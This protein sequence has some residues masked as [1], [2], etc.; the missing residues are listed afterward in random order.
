[1]MMIIIII[2]LQM[3]CQPGDSVYNKQHTQ[4]H[5][6]TLIAL[7]IKTDRPCG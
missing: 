2:V 3:G 1:M 6:T 5:I 7:I 4:I